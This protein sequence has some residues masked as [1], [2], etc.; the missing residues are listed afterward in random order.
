VLSVNPWL[1][2]PK[3]RERRTLGCPPLCAG[4]AWSPI[5]CFFG[6]RGS[7]HSVSIASE[8]RGLRSTGLRGRDVCESLWPGLR[9][10]LHGAM[11]S[12]TRSTL[13]AP[14]TN[15]TIP[16]HIVVVNPLLKFSLESCDPFHPLED[17]DNSFTY[18]HL[19]N[20]L[21]I[22]RPST[23]VRNEERLD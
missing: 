23:L 11:K 12:M 20:S 14:D 19:L 16:Q 9:N 2:A 3:R 17:V 5:P 21:E 7:R 8:T 6:A 18:Y 10:Q 15:R 22:D 1:A 4:S 13:S